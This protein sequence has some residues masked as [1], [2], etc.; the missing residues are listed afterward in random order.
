MFSVPLSLF[1][2]L[3]APPPRTGPNLGWVGDTGTTITTQVPPP[4]SMH[5]VICEYIINKTSRRVV[6]NN[7][8]LAFNIPQCRTTNVS[9][10]WWLPP[11]L[12]WFRGGRN[13]PTLTTGSCITWLPELGSKG[14]LRS[15]HGGSNS[16]RPIRSRSSHPRAKCAESVSEGTG[17]TAPHQKQIPSKSLGWNKVATTV[18]LI[19]LAVPSNMVEGRMREKGQETLRRLPFISLYDNR[20]TKSLL[21]HCNVTSM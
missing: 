21:H 17:G 7:Y 10:H 8:L 5:R 11:T 4:P 16:V 14:I 6:G 19:G 15:H 18:V 12:S 20:G 9:P 3:V 1:T 2:P 13:G